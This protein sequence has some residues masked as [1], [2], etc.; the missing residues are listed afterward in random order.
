MKTL[1]QAPIFKFVLS[2]LAGIV[3]AR[4]FF[5]WSLSAGIAG[6][7][8]LVTIRLFYGQNYSFRREYL[9][10]AGI[11]LAVLG[12][13]SLNYY[14]RTRPSDLPMIND[15]NCEKGEIYATVIRPVKKTFRGRSTWAEMIAYRKE[16][17]WIPASGRFQLY[18]E[19]RDSSVLKRFDKVLIRGNVTD[20]YTAN[21]GYLNYLHN[22]GIFHTVYAEAV[23]VCG[24]EKGGYVSVEMLRQ[25]ICQQLKRVI[26]D[27]VGSA[28]AQAMFLGEKA[29][30]TKE[31][32]TTFAVAG[33]SHI[34]AISGLHVAIVFLV[35]NHMLSPLHLLPQ[36]VRI[37]NLFILALLLVYMFIT[38]ASPAVVRS[39]LMFVIVL[40]FKVIYFRYDILNITGTAGLI[41]LVIDPVTAFD[42][43]F[44]LSYAAVIGIVVLLPWFD[45]QFPAQNFLLKNL[46]A[47]INVT[48]CATITTLPLLI[49][50]FG[51]F[52]T[53]FLLS[54]ILVSLLSFVL[55][56]VGF[57]TV[58]FCYVPVLGEWLGYFCEK[59]IGWLYLIVLEIERLPAPVIDEWR[60]DHTGIRMVVLQLVVAGVLLAGSRVLYKRKQLSTQP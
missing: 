34:L 35:L 21:E 29:D 5:S 25:D 48:L 51:T 26:P 39:V 10:A 49:F 24:R 30:M 57:F 42:I 58:I 41:Q 11:Y 44:Q 19:R 23:Q 46:F 37:K 27:S 47:W 2:Y 18:I 15:I 8:L 50:H 38:G 12:F 20:A 6:V 13:G 60:M 22:Q 40:I 54:N 14:V 36:G 17:E 33:I 43:G 32:K 4:Y 52:P 28:V 9:A 45:R 1:T 16:C 56:L 3:L 7:G 53:Y 59:L 31:L 55:V